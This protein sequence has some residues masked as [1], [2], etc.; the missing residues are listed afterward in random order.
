MHLLVEAAGVE[1]AS[2][3]SSIQLSSGAVYL[4]IFPSDSADKQ[5]LMEG[6][7]LYV[8]RAGKLSRNV[9]R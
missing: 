8:A 1:P 7:P 2:E 9:D 6:I 4:L 3:N 5:A